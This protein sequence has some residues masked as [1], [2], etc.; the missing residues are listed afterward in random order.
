MLQFLLALGLVTSPTAPPAMATRHFTATLKPDAEAPGSD[1]GA[2]GIADV[3]IRRGTIEYNLSIGELNHV[4]NVALLDG[5]RAVE[6]Y[7]G[8]ESRGGT[9]HATGHISKKD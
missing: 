4:T 7:D 1:A 6:L 5:N 3:R 9:L 8:P 2:N